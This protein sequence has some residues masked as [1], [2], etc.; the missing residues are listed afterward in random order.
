MYLG[1]YYDAVVEEAGLSKEASA[2]PVITD[3]DVEQV[4]TAEVI[5]ELKEAGAEF[6]TEEDAQAAIAEVIEEDYAEK[7]A[8][9]CN[10]FDIDGI[11]FDNDE[12]KVASAMQIVDGWEQAVIVN[13]A[14][15]E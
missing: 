2:E 7:V 3:E 5:E 11:E 13:A 8:S 10:E 15:Q 14:N 4:K 12:E 9:V 6:E 1:D